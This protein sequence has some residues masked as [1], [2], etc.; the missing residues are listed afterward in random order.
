MRPLWLTLLLAGGRGRLGLVV[1]AT[2]AVTSLLLVAASIARLPRTYLQQGPDGLVGVVAEPGTRPGVVLALLLLA[3]PLL[4][5]LDQAVRLGSTA[6]IRR[7]EALRV[8]GATT[9]DLRRWGAAEVGLTALVGGLLGVPLWLLLRLALLHPVGDSG[10]LLPD[11]AGPGWW[12]WPLVA[13]V[14]AYGA[15][16]GLRSTAGPEGRSRTSD[17][18]PRPWW[19]L[20]LAALVLLVWRDELLVS[21]VGGVLMVVLL[22][23]TLALLAPTA[24]YLAAGVLVRRAPSAAALLA[25]RRLV[26]DPGPAGRAAAAAGAVGVTLGVVPVFIGSLSAHG[27]AGD[28]DYYVLPAVGAGVCALVALLVIAASLAVHSTE[29]V[30]V[31]RRELA[32]LVATGVPAKVV[33]DSQ[34]LECVLVTVP[35]AVLGSL[36]GAVGYAVLAAD[37]AGATSEV[38]VGLGSTAAVSVLACW[39]ATAVLRPWVRDAVDPENLRTA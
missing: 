26:A 36:V 9:G 39:L 20:P 25:G 22:T 33:G 14:T 4:L 18:R 3:V 27:A 30:L 11:A 13:A 12:T 21:D 32:T 10:A 5:L 23:L 19:L 6:R 34:R 1:G 31:R 2:A 28:R 8:A 17:R 35:L 37:L 15:L 29:T 38:L 16:V 24:A 7:A